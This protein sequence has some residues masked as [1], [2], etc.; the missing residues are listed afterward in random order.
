MCAHSPQCPA[1]DSAA[2]TLAVVIA[3]HHEQG[4][5]LLCNG[6]VHFDDGAD[7]LPGGAIAGPGAISGDAAFGNCSS[8][9]AVRAR[10]A[11]SSVTTLRR[12]SG[13]ANGSRSTSSRIQSQNRASE[14]LMG[15]ALG[16]VR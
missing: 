7:L 6:V 3:D 11:F 16:R 14:R 8:S 5:T 12:S 9:G 10:V 1:A 2:R 4:W 13:Y 15:R